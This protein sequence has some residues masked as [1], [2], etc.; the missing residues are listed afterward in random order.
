MSLASVTSRPS[1]T[2]FC[3]CGGNEVTACS[4]Q[5]GVKMFSKETVISRMSETEIY[6]DH[7]KVA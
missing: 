6:I 5:A 2:S 7:F 3:R 1:R 4:I